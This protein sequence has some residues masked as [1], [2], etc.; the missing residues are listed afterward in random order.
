MFQD[1]ECPHVGITGLPGNGESALLTDEDVAAR[2]VHLYLCRQLST[3][4]IAATLGV[5]RRRVGRVL[6]QRG[7][8]VQPGGAGR[9]RTTGFRDGTT[10]ETLQDLYLRSRLSVRQVAA[11]TGLSEQAVRDRLL[12]SGVRLRTRGRGE[13]QD[14]WVAQSAAVRE[15]YVRQGLSAAETGRRLGVSGQIVLRTAHDLGFPVRVGGVEPSCGPSEMVLVAALYADPLVSRALARHGIPRVPATGPIWQRFPVS[16]TVSPELA[17]DLYVQ[18]GLS[19]RH[20][21]LLSGQPA[22]TVRGLLR[23]QGIRLRTAGGRS[24]FIRRWRSGATGA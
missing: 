5:D 2:V 8:P 3:Y 6:R 9:P 12:A 11:V 13:R 22:E 23:R 21:E 14:R 20:I 16:L 1:A 17:C 7:V 10:S 18:C 24:P 4:R 19:T 15:L